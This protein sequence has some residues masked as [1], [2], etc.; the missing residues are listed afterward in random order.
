MASAEDPKESANDRLS[1][2]SLME[3]AWEGQMVMRF[4]CIVLF[5]DA[6]LVLKGGSGLLQWSTSTDKLWQDLGFLVVAAATF[7]LLVSFVLP[8]LCHLVRWI[9][10]HIR[11]IADRIFEFDSRD[12]FYEAY[13]F[14]SAHVF[15][16]YAL[17]KES[18]LLLRMY[19]DAWLRWLM[20]RTELDQVG[21]LIFTTTFLAVA[22]ALL[23]F[24]HPEGRSLVHDALAPLGDKGVALGSLLLVV[25]GFILDETWGAPDPPIRVYYPPLYLKLAE[26]RRQRCED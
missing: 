9:G 15:R 3:K 7:G 4:V 10:Y 16:D 2:L 6:A 1:H 24:V 21:N 26:E 5:V 8:A 17:E 14:V 13:G 23:A 20:R 25:A 11:C 18:E 22:D 19:D 12:D